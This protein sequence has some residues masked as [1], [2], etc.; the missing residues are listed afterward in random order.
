MLV[1]KYVSLQVGYFVGLQMSKDAKF[2]HDILNVFNEHFDL[3]NETFL[4]K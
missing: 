1:C 2:I 3:L 4:D